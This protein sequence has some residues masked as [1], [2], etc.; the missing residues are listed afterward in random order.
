[1]MSTGHCVEEQALL[2]EKAGHRKL[3]AWE[4]VKNALGSGVLGLQKREVDGW[5][6]VQEKSKVDFG[7]G[8]RQEQRGK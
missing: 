2:M 7:Y 5:T 6:R 8:V 4:G 3:G 1:M